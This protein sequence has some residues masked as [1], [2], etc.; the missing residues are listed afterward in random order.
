MND[1]KSNTIKD[2]EFA[3][4]DYDELNQIKVL[5]QKLED[6]YYLIAYRKKKKH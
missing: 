5:E 1:L 2:A 3:N 4:L 6:K